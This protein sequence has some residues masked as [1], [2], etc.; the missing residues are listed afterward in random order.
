MMA[1]NLLH[2]IKVF[3][4]ASYKGGPPRIQ[5]KNMGRNKPYKYTPGN[6]T[7]NLKRSPWK[8]RFRTW[9]PSFSGSMLNFGGVGVLFTPGF[10]PMYKISHF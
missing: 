7:R 4:F 9:K 1:F 10:A 8:R 3:L 6:L 5:E 2:V